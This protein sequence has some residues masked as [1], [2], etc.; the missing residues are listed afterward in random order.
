VVDLDRAGSVL[1]TTG[2]F[3]LVYVLGT[4]AAVRLLPRRSWARRAAMFSFVCVTGVL[5]LTGTAVFWALGV[6]ALALVYGELANRR[7]NRAIPASPASIES[8][9][10]LP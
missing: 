8:S 1:L 2:S 10:A 6:A 4:A 5:V 3:T 9:C 7:T